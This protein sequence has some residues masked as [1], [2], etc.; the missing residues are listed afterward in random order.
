MQQPI[1][2]TFRDIPHSPAVTDRIR[3]KAEKL[4]KFSEFIISCHVIIEYSQKHQQ[5]GQL[6]NVRLIVNLPEKR[7]LAVNHH[8]DENMY[9]A[10][11]DA[12]ESMARKIEDTMQRIRGEVKIHPEKMQGKIVRLFYRDNFGFIEDYS[13]VEYYFNSDNIVHPKFSSL[14]EGDTVSFIHT[15]G[16]EGPCAHRVSLRDNNH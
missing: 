9:I 1:Q 12:F 10:I 16:D 7:T 11:R 5:Q 15:V 6:Y 8:E 14:K 2:I 13:G 3:A 4:Q